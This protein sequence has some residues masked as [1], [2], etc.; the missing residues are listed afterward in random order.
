MSVLRV[1]PNLED[2]ADEF[3]LLRKVATKPA[4]DATL[5][6]YTKNIRTEYVPKAFSASGFRAKFFAIQAAMD[7]AGAVSDNATEIS[8]RLNLEWPGTEKKDELRFIQISLDNYTVFA[9]RL[10]VASRKNK[11]PDAFVSYFLNSAGDPD[12]FV[13]WWLRRLN[14]KA[15]NSPEWDGKLLNHV[16][17]DDSVTFIRY[18]NKMCF[19]WNGKQNQGSTILKAINEDC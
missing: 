17:A 8:R 16:V 3:R 14:G 9:R 18:L 19:R 1:T 15:T 11:L 13:A 5:R 12:S 2:W 7:R 10:R 4:I 6:W